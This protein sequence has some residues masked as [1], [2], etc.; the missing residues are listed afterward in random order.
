[1]MEALE[2]VVEAEKKLQDIFHQIDI[3]E[4]KNSEK[5]QQAF[6][7]EQLDMVTMMWDVIKLNGFLLKY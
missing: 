3:V 5:V 6:S 7:L 2:K 1:M 4:Q